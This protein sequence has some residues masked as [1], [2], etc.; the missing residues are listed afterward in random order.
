MSIRVYS[1]ILNQYME[2]SRNRNAE[3]SLHS[4]NA[5]VF[6]ESSIFTKS[7]KIHIT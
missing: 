2:T 7:M 1:S 5:V 4:L 3:F 6:L